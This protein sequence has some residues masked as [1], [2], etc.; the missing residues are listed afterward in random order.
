MI[1]AIHP[2]AWGRMF[3]PNHM[4]VT[5]ARF[6]W[7]L[8][9]LLFGSD[10]R[11]AVAAPRGHAKSTFMDLVCLLYGAAHR[12]FD[13]CILI[14]DS[15]DQ[16]KLQLEDL[17]R[18][19]ETNEVLIATYPGLAPGKPWRED[20]LVFANG[21]RITALGA[22]Q[23]VRG[24]K[25]NGKR[26]DL[27]ICDDLENDEAVKTIERRMKL[28]RWFRAGVLPAIHPKRGRVRVVGTI[29]HSDS[30]LSRLLRT[31]GWTRR[32]WKALAD[33]GR[34]L[35]PEWRPSEQLLREKEEARKDGM[36]STWY[37]EFQ[38]ISIADEE[39]PFRTEDIQYFDRLPENCGHVYRSLYVDP[40]IG[41]DAKNDFTAYTVVYATYDGH[42]YVVEAFRR[43]HDPAQMIK[44]IRA[45]HRK[46]GLDV[47][48]VESV[49]FQRSITFWLSHRSEELEDD[50]QEDLS[51]MVEAII[52]DQDKLRR[53][54][55]LQPFYRAHR[56]HHSNLLGNRLEHELLNLMSLDHEDVADSLAGHLFI[57]LRPEAPKRRKIR[58]ADAE[59]QRAADHRREMARSARLRRR[60]IEE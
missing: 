18:E 20:D 45:L 35:W 4:G 37:Q 31:A 19:C 34:A 54:L 47:I 52:P 23:K 50:D 11:V 25:H 53:I 2:V 41:E 22:G 40:A 57:T 3:L 7:E 29:L 43:K 56:I 59:S 30:L 38:N 9:D 32:K 42:W 16:A 1:P 60:G 36:L 24:R 28:R 17:R 14:S 55:A 8:G 44:T 26:P 33:D 58:M 46:H 12:L 13:F 6:H 15:A 27:V 10:Q 51:H 48:G 5:P 49:A 39:N 21:V